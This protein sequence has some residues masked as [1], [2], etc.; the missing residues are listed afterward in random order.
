[1]NGWT[2]SQNP[3]KR[4]KSH[5]KATT[6]T[7]WWMYHFL[8]QLKSWTYHLLTDLEPSIILIQN[9]LFRSP[10]S[11]PMSLPWVWKLDWSERTQ[12]SRRTSWTTPTCP[13]GSPCCTAWDS[14]TPWCKSVASLAPSAGTSPTSS[15]QRIT[16]PVYSLCRIT[17]TTWTSKRWVSTVVLAEYLW[18]DCANTTFLLRIDKSSCPRS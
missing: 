9:V 8:T 14:C 2:F 3:C 10:S 16:T 15:M 4:G 1:M 11:S 18:V 12:T 17:W 7:R 5:Q 13:S 6:S